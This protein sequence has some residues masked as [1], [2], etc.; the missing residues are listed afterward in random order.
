MSEAPLHVQ[1]IEL[2]TRRV[3]KR[4]DEHRAK[5]GQGLPDQDYQRMVGRIREA[6]AI[7]E[8]LDRLKKSS[9]GELENE[10]D[11]DSVEPTANRRQPRSR[12]S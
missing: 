6:T 9:L 3:E 8:D 1:V 11:N 12:R 7:L 5:A 2:I 4:R 10:E